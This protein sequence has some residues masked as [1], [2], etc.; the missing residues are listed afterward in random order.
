M[1]E[2][3]FRDFAGAIMQGDQARAASVLQDILALSPDLAVSS[4]A[5][6]AANMK[7]PSFMPKAM[8]LRTAVTAGSDDEIKALLGDCFGLEGD[9]QISALRAIHARYPRT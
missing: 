3:T 5:H 8:S 7:D 4:S 9:A 6:F 1:A 2:L